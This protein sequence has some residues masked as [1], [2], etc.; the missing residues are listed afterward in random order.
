MPPKRLLFLIN[1]LETGGWERDV[2]MICRHIDKSRYLPEVWTLRSGGENEV[3]VRDAGITV[4]NLE[5][6]RAID[7]IFSLRVARALAKSKFDLWHA[8]LPA[9]LYH[10]A[11]ARMLHRIR[12]PLV[13][14]EGTL[15]LSSPW[16]AP[17][18]RWAVRR[19]CAMLTANSRSSQ[20]FL[21]AQGIPP[22]E[23][24]IIP[25]GHEFDRFQCPLIGSKF[26]TD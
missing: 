12:A 26:A 1:T 24:A 18:F 10:A 14:S 25:N 16:C 21:A 5:R 8:F 2:A 6:R 22:E 3:L 20:M 4:R 13:Y 7:P 17:I 23:I 11:L 9:I 19:Q 15:V